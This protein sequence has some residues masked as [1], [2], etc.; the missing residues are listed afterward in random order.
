LNQALRQELIDTALAMNASGLNSGTSGNVSVRS[1]TF[2]QAAFLITPSRRDYASLKPVD[3]V[4]MDDD[5]NWPI[6]QTPSSEWRFHRDIY[7]H[8]PEVQAVVHAHP[9]FSAALACLRRPIPAFHYMVT[10]AG[11]VDI[12]CSDYA[13]FGTQELSNAVLQA[14]QGRKAC[15]MANHG[16]LATGSDLTSALALAVEVE[17]LA[18]TYCQALRLGEP[19][20]LDDA[21]MLRVLEKFKKQAAVQSKR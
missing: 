13:T 7:A 15:L 3:V 6:D 18:Q 4:A 16:L 21:E 9:V 2:G 1:G 8:R 14:L 12:P 19:V 17:H 11:G 20:L 10:V 5:G